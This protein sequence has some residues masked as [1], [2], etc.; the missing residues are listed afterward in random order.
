MVVTKSSQRT[1]LKGVR[2]HA[3]NFDVNLPSHGL[4]KKLSLGV[5]TGEQSSQIESGL[6]IANIG[7][8]NQSSF[9]PPANDMFHQS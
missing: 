8:S 6:H 4:V 2:K 3:S 9:M 7:L 1:P 5:D